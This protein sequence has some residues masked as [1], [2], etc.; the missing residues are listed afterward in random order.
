[1]AIWRQ[2]GCETEA[3]YKAYLANVPNY[4]CEYCGDHNCPSI[5]YKK[6]R[7]GDTIIY[8]GDNMDKCP[9]IKAEKIKCPNGC[10]RILVDDNRWFTEPD[11]Y[12][13]GGCHLSFG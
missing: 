6:N 13:D 11:K 5:T 9:A 1:M 7:I 3:E 10:G 12:C 2:V 8:L 4:K